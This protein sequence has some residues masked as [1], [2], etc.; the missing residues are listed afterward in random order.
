MSFCKKLFVPVLLLSIALA[1]AA[2]AQQFAD[3]PPDHWAHE[4]VENL[5]NRGLVLGYPDGRFLGGRSLTRY[6]MATIIKRVLDQIDQKLQGAGKPS[7][8]TAQP[9]VTKEDLETI[10]KLV[11]EFKVELTVI[12]TKMDEAQKDLAVLREQLEGMK[13]E[14]ASAK[15][16]AEEAKAQAAAAKEQADEIQATLADKAESEAV[17]QQDVASLKKLKFS[18]Y[19][20][21]RFRSRETE[22]SNFT[23]RRGRLKAVYSGAQS[24]YT[25]QI[26]A[27]EGGVAL[28]DAYGEWMPRPN[29]VFW[30]GQFKVPFGFEIEQSSSDREMPERTEVIRALFPGERDRG[31]RL[32]HLLGSKTTLDLGV[33]NGNGVTTA[34]D[35]DNH[36]NVVARVKHS[37]TPSWDLGL[38]GY[39]GKAKVGASAEVKDTRQKM[40]GDFNG[41]GVPETIEVTVPGKPAVPGV[42]GKQNRFGIDMQVYNIFGCTLKGEWIRGKQPDPKAVS[43]DVQGWYALLNVPMGISWLLTSRYD[44][45]DPDTNAVNDKFRTWGFAL[46][47]YASGNLKFTAAYEIPKRQGVSGSNNIFTFQAQQ[48]F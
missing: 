14:L 7:E 15:Q 18:G 11:E 25:L 19:I 23:V 34:A 26:D 37:I 3:I 12:G 27:T 42:Y 38:S 44:E 33:F 10:R 17:L 30:F 28:R 36:K 13:G 8:P 9:Q 47:Y 22:K 35:Q 16:T 40:T 41:D 2:P 45:Y 1:S 39:W 21:S 48:K 29:V 6:E 43:K 4:A 32:T 20:Q 5:A 46:T 31:I 24:N